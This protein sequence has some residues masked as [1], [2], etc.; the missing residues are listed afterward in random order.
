M[1]HNN[2]YIQSF[3]LE[4]FPKSN[5]L[6][7]FKRVEKFE[8]GHS[9]KNYILDCDSILVTYK[10]GKNRYP[11]NYDLVDKSEIPNFETSTIYGPNKIFTIRNN[12][13][14]SNISFTIK[15]PLTST[16]NV[17]NTLPLDYDPFR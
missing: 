10:F 17:V 3:S 4:V 16:D 13:T 5:D 11:Y 7:G 2:T 1:Y 15:G 8:T 12:G 14:N 6:E 9:G